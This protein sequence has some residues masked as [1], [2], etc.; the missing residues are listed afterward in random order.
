V[1]L[2]RALAQEPHILL[3]DEPFTGVDAVT[4]DATLNLLDTLRKQQ[5]TVLVSTHDLSLAARRFDLTALL[6]HRLVA[7]GSSD[8]VFTPEHISTAFHQV[9]Y[10]NG[11]AIVD[12]CCGP[13]SGAHHHHPEEEQA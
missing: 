10:V 4:Q 5:V 7:F 12:D 8:Q 2:A 3:M 1:F 11:A 6:N 13:E 9:M